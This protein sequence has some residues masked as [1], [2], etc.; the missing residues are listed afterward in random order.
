MYD[1][2]LNDLFLFEFLVPCALSLQHPMLDK[3]E[4][5]CGFSILTI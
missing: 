2:W 1:A 5:R 3:Y 4:Q